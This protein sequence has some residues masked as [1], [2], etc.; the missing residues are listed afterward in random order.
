[1]DGLLRYRLRS[2]QDARS[3]HQR[4]PVWAR[5]RQGPID[6]SAQR[7]D[8]SDHSDL[9]APLQALAQKELTQLLTGIYETTNRDNSEVKLSL[10]D[11]SEARLRRVK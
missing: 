2:F 3:E 5:K 7:N 11:L 9:V 6:D 10:R 8:H 1:M 4:P